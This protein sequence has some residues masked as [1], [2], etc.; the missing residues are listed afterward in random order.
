[1]GGN[2]VSLQSTSNVLKVSDFT[3]KG[4]TNPNSE[5]KIMDPNTLATLET[6]SQN[7]INFG[8]ISV[9]ITDA[10][11]HFATKRA[12]VSAASRRAQDAED[13]NMDRLVTLEE[14]IANIEDADLAA[15][16][17]RIEM[18]MTQ[19]EAAQATFTRI[20]SKSLFDFLG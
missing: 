3:Q 19:K 6:V 13:A 10:F 11:E 12:E 2:R 17:T 18:L 7:N 4:M 1:V 20:T 16:L 8:N 9:R 14:D 15:L 5:L